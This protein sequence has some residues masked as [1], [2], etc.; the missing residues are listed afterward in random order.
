MYPLK[1]LNVLK[2][3]Q[4][5]IFSINLN[6]KFGEKNQEK[7]FVFAGT[8]I[9]LYNI[10]YYTLNLVI[11]QFI[12]CIF[13]KCYKS[14]ENVPAVPPLPPLDAAVR[15]QHFGLAVMEDDCRNSSFV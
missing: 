1:N 2:T 3:L 7:Y 12:S 4:E 13:P 15:W 11:K 14:E 9:V 6:T 10:T 5:F 8:W